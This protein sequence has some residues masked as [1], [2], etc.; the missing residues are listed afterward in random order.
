[1]ANSLSG[2]PHQHWN[3]LGHLLAWSGYHLSEWDICINLLL[4][5]DFSCCWPWVE[6]L[7]KA[8]LH[9]VHWLLL[10]Y[11]WKF[12][13][14]HN[15]VTGPIIV[16]FYPMYELCYPVVLKLYKLTTASTKPHKLTPMLTWLIS[17]SLLKKF[18]K[19]LIWIFTEYFYQNKAPSKFLPEHS[20]CV[21]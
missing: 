16:A 8:G 3:V 20:S 2:E 19:H 15:C 18:C 7:M 10:F 9:H 11:T 17:E 4:D 21:D 12:S 14:Q 1:M 5:L 6:W 13:P